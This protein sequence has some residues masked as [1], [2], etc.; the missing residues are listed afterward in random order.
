MSDYRFVYPVYEATQDNPLPGYEVH[1]PK[2]KKFKLISGT[3]HIFNRSYQE[4]LC[5][6]ERKNIN[7]GGK[8]VTK[9]EPIPGQ[10]LC[11]ECLKRY[12]TGPSKTAKR[13][14]AWTNGEPWTSEHV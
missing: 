9:D 13:L 4:F 1:N 3:G 6:I 11:A 8:L 10:D 7:P 5:G 2:A 12:T 14:R